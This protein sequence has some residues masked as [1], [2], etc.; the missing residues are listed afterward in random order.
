MDC[1][2]IAKDGSDFVINGTQPVSISSAYGVNCTN[3]LSNIIEVQLSKPTLHQ[4]G[5]LIQTDARL[6]L[7]TSGGASESRIIEVTVNDGTLDSNAARSS[8]STVS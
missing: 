1:N 7:G 2:S 6:N 4:Y 5:T 8:I 3:G